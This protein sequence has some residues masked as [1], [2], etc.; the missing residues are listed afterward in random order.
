MTPTC[1]LPVAPLVEH[2]GRSWADDANDVHHLLSPASTLVDAI[3]LRR[4][5]T[6]GNRWQRRLDRAIVSGRI[7]LEYGEDYCDLVGVHPTAI[8]GDDYYVCAEPALT[9]LDLADDR[10]KLDEPPEPEP[11]DQFC[12]RPAAWRAIGHER[13][14]GIYHPLI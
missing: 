4:H 1:W 12:G 5:T 6:D 9:A 2:I 10:A 11:H 8:W 3:G 13:H 14:Y 7:R